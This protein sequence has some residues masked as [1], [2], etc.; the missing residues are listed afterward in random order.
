M[1]K[2]IVDKDVIKKAKKF[3]K[4]AQRKKLAEFIDMI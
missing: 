4:P 1:Y 2:V 3:L